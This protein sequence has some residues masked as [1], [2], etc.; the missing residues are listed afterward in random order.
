M[1]TTPHSPKNRA[2]AELILQHAKK[3]LFSV[4]HLA[5]EAI[6]A[7]VDCELSP[8]ARKRARLHL[9][10][11]EECA[12]EVRTQRAASEA[13]NFC[14]TSDEVRASDDLLAKLTGIAH[15]CGP[16]PDASDTPCPKPEE[17]LDKVE[18]LLRTLKK[19][20]GGA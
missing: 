11:C 8:V 4:D 7:Y 5:P 6:A 19:S 12:H 14:N 13:L 15:K 2:K 17:M 1:T 9:L 20:T 18:T 10:Q 3:V 16:G